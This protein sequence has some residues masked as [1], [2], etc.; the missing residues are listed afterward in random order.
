MSWW[1]LSLLAT[2]DNVHRLCDLLTDAGAN[3]VSMLGNCNEDIYEPPPDATA[4]WSHTRVIGMFDKTVD[5]DKVL[6]FLQTALQLPELPDHRIDQL[7][8][9]DWQNKWMENIRPQ[10]FGNRLWVYPSWYTAPPEGNINIILDPGLAFGT[11]T[12]PTTALCLEWLDHHNVTGWKIID[13]GC[14]SGI[15]SIASIKL[16]AAH[17]WAVDIDP[18]ALE[19]TIQNAVRND[20][21]QYISPIYPM[22]LPQ[23]KADCLI[24]NIL[25]NPILELVPSF[26]NLVTSGGYII[27]SGILS[28][29][30]ESVIAA[31]ECY[32]HI[33]EV[34]ER[35]KWVR[36]EA[37]R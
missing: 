23:K 29:Q 9:E 36:I 35:E 14:G 25:A 21:N 27:L 34:V 2:P 28:N 4:L 7:D 10:S 37:I 5:I 22:D 19:A 24:A 18:Q 33:D 3:T 16:G 17:V 1:Q 32:F 15:L 6:K 8:D 12:H 11:G 20:V 13:Y 30:T 31:L 26:A